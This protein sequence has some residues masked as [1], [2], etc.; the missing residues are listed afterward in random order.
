MEDDLPAL[1]QEGGEAM[2]LT[3]RSFFSAAAAAVPAAA[4][5]IKLAE[6][7]KTAVAANW[8]ALPEWVDGDAYWGSDGY[9]IYAEGKWHII[10]LDLVRE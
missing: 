8:S 2:K 7:A 9:Y 6:Q 3:R 1:L 10:K 5:G 4:V